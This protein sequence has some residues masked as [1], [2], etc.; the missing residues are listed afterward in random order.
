[1][2]IVICLAVL[3]V[4]FLLVMAI[5]CNRFVIRTYRCRI[6]KLK[7][8]GRA[9]LLSD[10]HNKSFGKEN[11]RLL[12]AIDRVHP[13]MI[14]I[15]GDMY[16][17]EKEADTRTAEAFVTKL[18]EKYPVYYGNGNHE[19]KTGTCPEEYGRI[20][21][22]FFGRME[23]AGVRHLVNEKVFLPEFNMDIYGAGISLDYYGK[24]NY[25]KMDGDY[26]DRLLGRP[27][28][29]RAC[30]LIAHNPDYFPD[31]VRWGAD[32]VVSGHIHG[33]LMRFPV[34]GGAISPALR[35]FPKYDG[36]E[37]KEGKATM[38]LSRGLGTHTIPVRIFNPGE[39]VVVEFGR[40]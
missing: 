29:S 1:L 22:D 20:Y 8:D 4:F 11:E 6:G 36:G 18:A 31:Y 16:T 9:V 19:E 28:P 30:V 24:F 3:A 2:V 12:E 35:I 7:K 23:A 15:A 10:L 17:C 25:A 13:D 33:G 21:E 39:L 5:D 34:L 40:E 37:F 38:I 26:L 14:W 27:D 32:L